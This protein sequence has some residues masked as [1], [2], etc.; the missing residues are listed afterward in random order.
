MKYREYVNVVKPT[1]GIIRSAISNPEYEREFILQ[2]IDNL[3]ECL[4]DDEFWAS[5]VGL[6]VNQL[7]GFEPLP[8]INWDYVRTLPC[9]QDDAIL[10]EYDELKKFVEEYQDWYQN[11]SRTWNTF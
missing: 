8:E 3:Q 2:L 9:G 1:L 6:T 5:S 4:K 10:D 11:W 7:K